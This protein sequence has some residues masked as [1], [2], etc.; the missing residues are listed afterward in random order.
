MLIEP[1][2]QVKAVI[3]AAPTELDM[4]HVELDEQRD[5]DAQVLGGLFLGQATNG[6]QR[7][8]LFVHHQPREARR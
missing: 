5:P 6:R 4:G 2:I 7:Q 3:H 8:A 1:G